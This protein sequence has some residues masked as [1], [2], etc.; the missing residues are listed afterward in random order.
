MHG[1]E[2]IHDQLQLDCY[3]AHIMCNDNNI[4]TDYIS[5]GGSNKKTTKTT[6]IHR[7]GIFKKK[8][9]TEF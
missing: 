1:V 3:V 9:K 4:Y 6:N 8:L 5:N 2:I 7:H